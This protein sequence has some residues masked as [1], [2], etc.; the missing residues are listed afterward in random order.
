[1]RFIGTSSVDNN[2][3]EWDL[4]NRA[5]DHQDSFK[6][7]LTRGFGWTLVQTVKIFNSRKNTPK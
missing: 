5:S 2:S 1:M 6:G 3:N 4:L 7:A